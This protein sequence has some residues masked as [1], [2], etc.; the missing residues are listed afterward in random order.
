MDESPTEEDFDLPVFS[1]YEW[2]TLGEQL[3][4]SEETLD[5]IAYRLQTFQKKQ[6]TKEMLRAWVQQKGS[7]A[8]RKA[9]VNALVAT[10]KVE[11]VH[12]AAVYKAHCRTYAHRIG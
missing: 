10:K 3:D 6:A 1:F 9:L 4:V 2:R 12:A 5:D 8:T 11:F 7:A